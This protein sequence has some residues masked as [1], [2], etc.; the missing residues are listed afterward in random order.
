MPVL[1]PIHMNNGIRIAP[2]NTGVLLQTTENVRLL[3]GNNTQFDP[4]PHN[5]RRGAGLC[6]L[7][8]NRIEILPKV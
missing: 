8:K 5:C 6:N 7:I 2:E 3:I 1:G 4:F